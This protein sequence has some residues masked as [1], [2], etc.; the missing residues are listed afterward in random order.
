MKF[1]TT[2]YY[3]IWWYLPKIDIQHQ[4]FIFILILYLG[5]TSFY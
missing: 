5:S 4:N 1:D 2:S 3:D